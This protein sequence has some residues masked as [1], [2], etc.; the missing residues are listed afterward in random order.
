MSG[1]C[2]DNGEGCTIVD[3]TLKN[4]VLPGNLGYT[5]D[6][7]L[8]PPWA[9]FRFSHPSANFLNCP[10]DSH[11]FSVTTGYGWVQVC[12]DMKHQTLNTQAGSLMAVTGS[13]KPVN[14]FIRRSIPPDWH[15]TQAETQI[16]HFYP[17]PESNPVSEIVRQMMYVFIMISTITVV[18]GFYLLS[19]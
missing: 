16:V 4:P 13:V 19:T 9:V 17:I 6:I 3:V 15:G 12:F 18:L 7:N 11:Q 8:S 5:V 14:I 1:S 2:G 10:P